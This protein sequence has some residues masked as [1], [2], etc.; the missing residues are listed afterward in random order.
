MRGAPERAVLL[1]PDDVIRPDHL[2]VEKMSPALIGPPR[3]ATPPPPPPKPPAPAPAPPQ[4]PGDLWS[5]VD[6]LE[7]RKI[8][9]ALARAAGNQ[10]QA[11]RL[12]GIP[13]GTLRKR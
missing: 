1:C 4:Q 2:P 9:D 11:A 3:Q 8:L 10:T 6:T 12:L 13:R 5:D 7:H